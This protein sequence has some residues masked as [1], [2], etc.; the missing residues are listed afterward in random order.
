MYKGV[1]GSKAAQKR[2]QYIPKAPQILGRAIYNSIF[3]LI[4][5]LELLKLVSSN[6]FWGFWNLQTFAQFLVLFFP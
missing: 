1:T 4:N 3:Y 5:S 2:S 6:S